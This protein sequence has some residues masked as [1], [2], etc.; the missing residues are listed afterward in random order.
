M[1]CVHTWMQ[2]CM[3]VGDA[4][5]LSAP[6]RHA[7]LAR[8]MRHCRPQ[9]G[10]RLSCSRSGSGAALRW[11][12]CASYGGASAERARQ[13]KGYPPIACSFGCPSCHTATLPCLGIVGVH[14]LWGIT[15]LASRAPYSSWLSV[16]IANILH[17]G[18]G[19]TCDW[20]RNLRRQLHCPLQRAPLQHPN[21][22][23]PSSPCPPPLTPCCSILWRTSAGI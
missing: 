13:C 6:S 4:R 5:L 7:G 14:G 2:E 12:R 23:R 19:E 16:S 8:A 3:H 11:T 10:W 9:Q 21:P 22:C 15:H 18:S 1:C 20:H 17:W